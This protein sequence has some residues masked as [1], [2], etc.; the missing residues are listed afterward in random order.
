M[1]IIDSGSKSGEH[2][3]QF[4]LVLYSRSFP[5]L[6]FGAGISAFLVE[7]VIATLE[8]KSL[9]TK[10]ELR[11][12]IKAANNVKRLSPG[13][14]GG[15]RI[16][17]ITPGLLSYVIA[18]DGPATMH[19]VYGWLDEIHSD[20]GI[21]MPTLDANED[22]RMQ[23]ISP[24]ID[25][26]VILG[27]GFIRFDNTPISFFPDA[28]R[29]AMP[30]MKWTIADSPDGNLLY[31]FLDLTSAATNSSAF[32]FQADRYLSEWDIPNVVYKK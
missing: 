26:I 9:I 14:S 24:S 13:L 11:H 10:E 31:L 27:K 3:N 23:T 1:E 8:I 6:D 15:L 32:R 12:A 19:T 22:V 30:E 21:I 4:D 20:L 16:G 5:K 28:M 25:G 29:Q 17:H 7:A 18:Y 2:R